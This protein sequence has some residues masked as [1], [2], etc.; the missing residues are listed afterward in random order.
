MVRIG[1]HNGHFHADEVLACALLRILPQYKEAEIVR[2]RDPKVL[3]G[4]D[5]VVDVGGV[6]EPANHRYDHHQRTFAHSF[7]SL[8]PRYKFTTKLSSAGLV[9]FHFG[10]E[11]ISTLQQTELSNPL[12]DKLFI[13]V[14]EKFIEE[15][16]AIDNGIS[17]HDT[18]GR[19]TINTNFSKR[20]GSFNP[21]WNEPSN[22]ADERFK[23]AMVAADQEFRDKVWY[24]GTGWWPARNVVAKAL[25]ARFSV[26]SSGRVL[27]LEQGGVPW[28]EHL[29]EL[30]KEQELG[31]GILYVIYT[32]QASNW[33][34][35]CVPER[36]DSFENRLSLPAAW[37]G[38]RDDK[39][40]EVSGVKGA[41]FVHA[42]GFIGGNKTKEG[43]MEMVEISLKAAQ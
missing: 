26:H 12:V 3:D 2:S 4:C 13:K 24:Y 40:E 22:D 10:R 9:Y 8:D 41:I 29:F 5:L 32:D 34:I 15:V 19:Y 30:E 43:I 21:L 14:Y 16:D 36:P 35:Q 25:E 1:T 39:L 38:V 7:N 23:K 42:S 11:I 27:M 33:R 17:T 31:E 37:R 18:E 20:I 28:K 6:F